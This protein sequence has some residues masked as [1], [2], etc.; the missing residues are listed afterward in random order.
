MK[1]VLLYQQQDLLVMEVKL[2][3]RLKVSHHTSSHFEL[4]HYTIGLFLLPSGDKLKNPLHIGTFPTQIRRNG[5]E[6]H[7][8][9][10]LIRVHTFQL[11]HMEGVT[12]IT[13]KLPVK[14]K[15]KTI[16]LTIGCSS[17]LNVMTA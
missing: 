10:L 7:T 8:I 17:V 16:L 11:V 9:Q 3:G 2:C 5:T 12:R 15:T 4:V 14:K 6:I 1:C 13:H